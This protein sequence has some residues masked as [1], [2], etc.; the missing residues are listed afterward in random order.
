MRKRSLL[1]WNEP[2]TRQ[3]EDNGFSVFFP[4]HWGLNPNLCTISIS[5][6]FCYF[7]T[8][9]IKSLSFPGGS[10]CDP[11][12]SCLSHLV[13]QVWPPLSCLFSNYTQHLLWNI[14]RIKWVH[15]YKL[16]SQKR[17]ILRFCTSTTATMLNTP[18]NPFITNCTF[19]A[20]QST[21]LRFLG[22]YKL[23]K[24]L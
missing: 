12:P 10:T 7:T 18:I 14:N 2:Q 17:I 19:A 1:F 6:T 8:G 21:T 5:T 13:I 15:G 24:F 4:Q 11:P 20:I 3:M 22:F 9:L 23:F 16:S